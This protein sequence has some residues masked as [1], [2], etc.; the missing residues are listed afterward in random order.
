MNTLVLATGNPNKVPELREPLKLHGFDVRLQTEFFSESVEEDG[1]SFVENALKKARYA[2]AKT[3]LP[4]VA[5]DSGIH[6][7]F[8]NGKPGIFSARYAATEGNPRP[9]ELENMYKLLKDLEGQ[10]LRNRHA[11]YVCAVVYV[12]HAQDELPLIGIGTWHGDIL[13]EPRTDYGIG[14]DPVM[15]IPSELRAAS[16][17]SLERK[18]EVS[19]RAVAMNK[20]LTQLKGF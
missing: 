17:V 2:S 9:T 14:Y 20:V 1:L 8:L 7:P 19:H 4:A 13:T 10:P 3:G 12:A 18:L 6:V 16:E 5:D 15:W 11:H